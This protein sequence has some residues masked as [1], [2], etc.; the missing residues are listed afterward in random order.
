M[1]AASAPLSMRR[2]LYNVAH[3]VDN[4]QLR[5][6]ADPEEAYHRFC[7]PGVPDEVRRLPAG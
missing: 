6:P 3:S 7:G 2:F 4:T 1:D 5:I